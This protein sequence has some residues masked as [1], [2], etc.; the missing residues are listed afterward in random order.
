MQ[1]TDNEELFEELYQE[2]EEQQKEL[3]EWYSE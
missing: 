3:D 1:L 2:Y